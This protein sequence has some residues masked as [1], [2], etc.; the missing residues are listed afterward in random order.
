[1][2]SFFLPLS[3]EH[4]FTDYK[5]AGSHSLSQITSRDVANVPVSSPSKFL[6]AGNPINARCA[7][8]RRD[9]CAKFFANSR[10]AASF[11]RCSVLF[12]F[13]QAMR[14]FYVLG[15]RETDII[16]LDVG[17]WLREDCELSRPARSFSTSAFKNTRENY[18]ES[19]I[20][21]VMSQLRD[22]L[23]HRTR[24]ILIADGVHLTNKSTILFSSTQRYSKCGNRFVFV[25]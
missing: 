23:F 9:L 1:M 12:F 4:L 14:P 15:I 18:P 19:F 13:T 24:K 25:K 21:T 7:N 3:I 11:K 22:E 2:P 17:A 10:Y 20:P 5:I 6:I 16:P 8:P